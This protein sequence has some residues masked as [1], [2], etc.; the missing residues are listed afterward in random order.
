VVVAGSITAGFATAAPRL[1]TGWIGDAPPPPKLQAAID[2]VMA[3]ALCVTA[4][5]A[6]EKL[7]ARLL[8]LG[9]D[10]WSVVRGPG[11]TSSGCVSTTVSTASRRVVLI[12]ALRPAVQNALHNV[13]NELLDEC[14]SEAAA[15]ALVAE[16]LNELG[17]RGWE[18]RTGGP[19]GGPIDR[20]D[21]VQRHVRDGC[22]IYSGTG[23]T[24]DG[25]RLFY[26]GGRQ[27]LSTYRE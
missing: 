14:L 10:D 17:E 20:L 26:V 5:E 1:P 11:V 6:E 19:I 15:M 24:E 2:A 21:E 12:M 23:W 18:L 13:A 27:D 9:W 3:P 4:T 7:G 25:V 8:G 22:F 16:T